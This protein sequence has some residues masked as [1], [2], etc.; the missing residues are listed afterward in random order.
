MTDSTPPT[1]REIRDLMGVIAKG[2]A[3][4]V[5]AAA[6]GRL[7]VASLDSADPCPFGPMPDDPSHEHR[8]RTQATRVLGELLYT[9]SLLSMSLRPDT[10]ESSAISYIHS[11]LDRLVRSPVL[12]HLAECP[13]E[14]AAH[15]GQ[16][17]TEEDR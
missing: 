11:G 6:L 9:A 5:D 2:V 14:P 17:E 3:A 13:G 10:D 7:V 8:L 4:D 15:H 12:R 16:E 1:A